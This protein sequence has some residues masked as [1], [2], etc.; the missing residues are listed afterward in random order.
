MI[1]VDLRHMLW[2]MQ[3]LDRAGHLLQEM[4]PRASRRLAQVR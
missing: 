1:A 4:G 3:V 2:Q